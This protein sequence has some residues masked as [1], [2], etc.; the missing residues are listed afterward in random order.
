MISD[1]KLFWCEET[2][3]ADIGQMTCDEENDVKFVDVPAHLSNLF[4]NFGQRCGK[5]SELTGTGGGG[6]DEM[7]DADELTFRRSHRRASRIIS[8]ARDV[9]LVGSYWFRGETYHLVRLLE[10][11]L[12]I[13]KRYFRDNAKGKNPLHFGLIDDPTEASQVGDLT[14]IRVVLLEASQ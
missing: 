4:R 1:S 8:H 2:D 6:G 5:I 3:S 12:I 13:G 11:V 9:S 10:P 7:S 14:V